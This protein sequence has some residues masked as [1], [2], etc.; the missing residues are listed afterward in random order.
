MLSIKKF[1][2]AFGVYGI[3]VK[4]DKLLVI[5]KNRGPYTNRLDL[6]GG[7]LEEGESLT[8]AMKREFK[9]ETGLEINIKQ[10]IGTCDFIL[11]WKWKGFN[12]VH[13]IAVF[14][15]VENIS[16]TFTKPVQFKGQDSLGAEWIYEEEVSANN[17]SPL[18]MKAFE[19]LREKELD[20]HVQ[21][22]EEWIVN[23]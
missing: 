21:C 12:H 20:F 15:E 18:V 13:H 11:P 4:E 10:N 9:E 19:W 7:S 3:C 1:H 2:R 17:A 22:Y 14:Y 5:N 16:D 6:P 23:T 8:S